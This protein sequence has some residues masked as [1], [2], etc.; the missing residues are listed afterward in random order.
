MP[1]LLEEPCPF[2]AQWLDV[3]AL[4]ELHPFSALALALVMNSV[5]LDPEQ[6]SCAHVYRCGSVLDSNSHGGGWGVALAAK[7]SSGAFAFLG[8]I[9]GPV[10]VGE[11]LGYMGAHAV[12]S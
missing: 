1:A 4:P 8:G 10:A 7:L 2:K 9:A 12:T 5:T 6:F 11:G 3:T